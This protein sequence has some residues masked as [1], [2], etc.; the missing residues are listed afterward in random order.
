MTA[1]LVVGSIILFLGLDYLAR[2]KKSVIGA[3]AVLL[4]TPVR[5][6][7]PAQNSRVPAFAFF[8]PG[9]TWLSLLD[10][11]T[12]R[13]GIDAFAVEALGRG[14]QLELP[15]VPVQVKAGQR[16]FGLKV[17]DRMAHF[18]APIDGEIVEINRNAS[19]AKLPGAWLVKMKPRRLGGQLK[20]L[21]VAEAAEDWLQREKSRFKDFLATLGAEPVVALQDGGEPVAGILAKADDEAWTKFQQ[22]FLK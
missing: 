9:H 3:S 1:V 16:I 18:V 2:R 7:Q 21:R 5:P 17:G 11:G 15:E 12:V 4:S 14:Q 20:N 6:V 13:V 10:N 19:P 8:H 22:E